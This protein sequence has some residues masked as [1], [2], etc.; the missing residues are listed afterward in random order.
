ME[1]DTVLERRYDELPGKERECRNPALHRFLAEYAQGNHLLLYTR[2]ELLEKTAR[3]ITAVAEWTKRF[4][5]ETHNDVLRKNAIMYREHSTY[6]ENLRTITSN[7][8]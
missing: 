6:I 8:T 2:D 5:E 1:E 4:A 3:R 7:P